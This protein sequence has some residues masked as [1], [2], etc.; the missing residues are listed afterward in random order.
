MRRFPAGWQYGA[1]IDGDFHMT[2]M[3]WAGE[4]I[5]QFQRYRFVQLYRT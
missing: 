5:H 1:T 3:G 4:A 2:Q